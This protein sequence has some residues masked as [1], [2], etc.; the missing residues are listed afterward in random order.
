MKILLRPLYALLS[1]GALLSA[2]CSNREEEAPKP[3]LA[4][5]ITGIVSPAGAAVRVTAL[6]PDGRS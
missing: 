6:G 4:G 5:T 2:G 1:M 3:A